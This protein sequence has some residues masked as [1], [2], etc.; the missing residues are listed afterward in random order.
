M[1]R[2]MRAIFN[3][4]VLVG[5]VVLLASSVASAQLTKI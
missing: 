4:V 2:E 3:G 5:C 1:R